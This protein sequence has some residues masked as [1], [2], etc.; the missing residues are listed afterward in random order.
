MNNDLKT[1]AVRLSP[2][3]QYQIRKNII[4]LSEKGKSNEEIAEILDVSLRHVQN[5]KKQ[6]KEGG[7]AGIK[8]QKRGRREG[9]KRTLTPAQEKEIQQILVD[10]T[11]DQLK[12]KDCMWSRKTIAEL[13]YEKYKISLPVSTLGVY[14]ARW[15]FSVQRPMKRAYKQDEEKVQHWVETEFPG[16]T[17]RAEAENAEIFFG[18]ETGLQNQSTC[19]RGYAPIGQTPVVRTEAKHIKINMLSAISNRGKLRFV[20]YKDNMNADKLIDFMRRLVHDSKKKVFLVLDNLRVHHAKKV[21]VWVEKHK[22]E[23]EL[24]YLPPYAP[25]IQSR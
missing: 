8:P 15:G 10:K 9:A 11:P 20:L 13:I 3:E 14:L 7:I 19:L 17:E 2:E 24:F 12:F 4:R 5:T 18:D 23:I 16:I 25:E 22:E 21:M 6:Y 1:Q